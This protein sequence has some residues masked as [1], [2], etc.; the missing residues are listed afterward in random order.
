MGPI[1]Y[2]RSEAR[3]DERSGRYERK[4]RTRAGKVTHKV[5]KLSSQGLDKAIIEGCRRGEPA[6]GEALADTDHLVIGGRS[7]R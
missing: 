3:K 5:P 1:R 2:E 4:L 7:D 6:V